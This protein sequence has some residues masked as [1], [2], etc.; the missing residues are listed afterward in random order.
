MRRFPFGR[1]AAV[2]FAAGMALLP[3]AASAALFTGPII[4]QSGSC[5]C[6]GSAPDWGC[7]LQVLQNVINF[8]VFLGVILCVVWIAYGGFSM[9]VSGGSVEARS[10]AKTRLL[11]AVVGIVVILCSWII[12]DFVMKTIYEPNSVFDGQVF[13]P[14]NSIL[15][16]EEDSYCIIP[17]TPQAIT[18]GTVGILLGNPTGGTSS[19][20]PVGQAG[21]LCPEGNPGCSV[22]SLVNRG[23]SQNQAQA[24]S[25]IAMTESSGNANA[26]NTSSRAC[27]IFQ[28][29][30][31]T[32]KSNWQNPANHGSGC[33][34]N[35]PCTNA[36][37]NAQTAVIMF[38]KS[39]YTPWTCR[40]CN[41]KAAACVAKYDPGH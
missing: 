12:V 32:S 16:P 23:L 6:A 26:I 11:N 7:V 21:A 40:G 34:V 28:I 19:A 13:G 8:A 37:C 9:M 31:Q 30:N 39:G 20:Y 36:S 35:T 38:Q 1:Y 15:A 4:P 14:W 22:Q 24:L 29:T 10:M 18:S 17:T 33:S 25:C 41:N 3:H 5:V 2:V 27:G